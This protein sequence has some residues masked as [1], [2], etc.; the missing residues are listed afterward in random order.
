MRA[1]D[2]WAAQS[3]S[4]MDRLLACALTPLGMIYGAATAHRATRPSRWQAPV[5]VIC[6]GNA[7]MGGS[8]KTQVCIDLCHRLSASG[9]QAHV[10]S[11]G[12]G[13]RLQGP[14]R[15]DP[16]KHLAADVGDE[17][18]VLAR[19][20]PTWIGADRTVTARAASAAGA[21][22]LIMDDGFQNPSLHR[23]LNLMVIDGGYG[24]GNACVFPAGPLRE[25]AASAFARADALCIVG[26]PG[27]SMPPLPDRLP[28]FQALIRPATDVVPLKDKQVIAVAGIGRPEKFF[29]TLQ[30]AGADIVKAHGFPD[31]H[32]F[33]DQEVAALLDDAEAAGAIVVTTEKDHARLSESHKQ[34]ITPFP[35][36]LEWEDASAL[37][38]FIIE[39]IGLN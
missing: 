10:L 11:R 12:Y 20:A 13:G 33:Q 2:F 26:T 36:R 22:V 37:E 14:V 39:R 7:V 31:H 5:P 34:R 6:V 21:G 32:A 25:S 3:T 17:A 23:D 4:V 18:L 16:Q 1:P 9:A 35:V 27:A 15:V 8:G 24:F 19:H 29:E 38:R 30:E 28:V